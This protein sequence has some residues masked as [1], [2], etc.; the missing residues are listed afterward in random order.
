[1]RNVAHTGVGGRNQ[2]RNY[3][4]VI[5]TKRRPSELNEVRHS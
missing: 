4:S 1:M 2:W 3:P 5:S